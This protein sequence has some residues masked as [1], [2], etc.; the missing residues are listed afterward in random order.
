MLVLKT[1]SLFPHN[2]ATENKRSMTFK[3]WLVYYL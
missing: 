3:Q 2:T 1:D